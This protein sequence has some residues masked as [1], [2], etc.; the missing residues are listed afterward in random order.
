MLDLL[1]IQHIY[2]YVCVEGHWSAGLV[3]WC[4]DL[5]HH[6]HSEQQNLPCAT[7]VTHYNVQ[8]IGKQQQHDTCS[9]DLF[10]TCCS[11]LG[12]LQQIAQKMTTRWK[13]CLHLQPPKPLLNNLLE[14][15]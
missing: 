11:Q 4:D 15:Q 1:T 12:Q 8:A 6:S 3:S 2:P 7:T 9:H 5:V 13:P 14:G 10:A